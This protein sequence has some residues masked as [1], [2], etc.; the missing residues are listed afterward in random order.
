MQAR[1][2]TVKKEAVIRASGARQNPVTIADNANAL[3]KLF[4]R[5]AGLRDA[6]KAT[7]HTL[8]RLRVNLSMALVQEVGQIS[9]I[10]H[11]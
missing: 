9:A 8:V 3:G 10:S 2:S 4:A 6:H 5:L 1:A 7:A 11:A